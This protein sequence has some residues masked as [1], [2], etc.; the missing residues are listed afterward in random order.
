[1]EKK[2]YTKIK[3]KVCKVVKPAYRQ[4]GPFRLTGGCAD[5]AQKS[6]WIFYA[7]VY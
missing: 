6:K 7:F 4:A 5:E 3:S 2:L 1:V